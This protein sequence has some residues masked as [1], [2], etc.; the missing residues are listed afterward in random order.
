VNTIKPIC[1]TTTLLAIGLLLA[2]CGAAP[3]T[4]TATATGATGTDPTVQRIMDTILAGRGAYDR[5]VTLC[6]SF[7]HRLSGSPELEQAIGWARDTLSQEGHE[8]VRLEPV[9]IP[10]WVRG[11]ESAVMVSPRIEPLHMLG[12]GMSLPTPP[13]GI[14]AEVVTVADEAELEALGAS[15]TGKIVHFNNPMPDWT[16]E[17][18]ACYGHTVRFRLFGANMAAKLGAKAIII[19]SVTAHS[20]RTPHTGTLVYRDDEPAIPAAAISTEDSDLLARLQAAGK[21]VQVRLTMNAR[22]DGESNSSNV[23]AEIVGR[24]LPDEVVIISGHIDSWDV[25]QGAHD[26]GSGVV[27]A[28]E[29]LGTLRALGLRPRRTIRLVLWTNEEN[30][31]AGV[32]QYIRDHEAELPQI[33]AAIEADAGGFAP[34]SFGVAHVDEDK[35]RAAVGRVEAMMPELLKAAQITVLPGRGAPDVSHFKKHGVPVIGLYTHGEHYFDYHHTEADTVDKVDPEELTRSA[36]AMAGLAW[37]IAEMPGRLD[38]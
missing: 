17:E 25:G 29:T 5:L 34:A 32:K 37:M 28:M 3:V 35:Q 19:R 22:R 11:E 38:D 33:V 36:A 16:P 31:M 2:G 20:L 10:K 18:G 12:L 23:V 13:E 14:T 24:E 26:D 8:N 21:P 1:L 9:M 4:D 27:M 6:D 7:G 30:G 15:V